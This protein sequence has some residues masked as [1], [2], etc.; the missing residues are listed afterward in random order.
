MRKQLQILLSLLCSTEGANQAIKGMPS[1][2]TVR[3]SLS[4]Y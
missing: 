2:F 4:Q 1:V 3:E